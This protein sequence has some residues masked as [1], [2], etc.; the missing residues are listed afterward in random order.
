MMPCAR[1]Y[2][3]TPRAAGVVAAAYG[4][5]IALLGWAIGRRCVT[6]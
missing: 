3:A 5:V 6:A 2:R 4:V 1:S